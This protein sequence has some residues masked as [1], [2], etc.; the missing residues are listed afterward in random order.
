MTQERVLPAERV[1]GLRA[2]MVYTV[3]AKIYSI[4]TFGRI[5]KGTL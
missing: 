4:A 5:C 2:L 3:R 1:K